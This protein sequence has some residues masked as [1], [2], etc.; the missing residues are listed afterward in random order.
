MSTHQTL[1][2][3]IAKHINDFPV[4]SHHS[5][6]RGDGEDIDMTREW[7]PGDKRIDPPTTSRTGTIMSR[8]FQESKQLNVW[9]LLD[10][11]HSMYFG[12]AVSKIEV[13][14]VIMTAIGISATGSRDTIG[15]IT[16]NS[17]IRHFTPLSLDSSTCQLIGKEI[18]NQHP[19]IQ[20]TSLTSALQRLA[21]ACQNNSLVCILSDFLTPPTHEDERL[22]NMI[23]SQP[24]VECVALVIRDDSQQK[25]KMPFMTSIRDSEDEAV[26][27][28]DARSSTLSHHEERHANAWEHNLK[29]VFARC[30]CPHLFLHI[31]TRYLRTLAR[32]FARKD[33]SL[34]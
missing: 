5:L 21:G 7:Q 30:R 28:T 19:P 26:V 29:Q 23:A 24:S 32:Y 11:S 34:A 25:I 22:M 33:A 3:L 15:V 27:S 18:L 1:Q 14:S 8:T 20:K 17:D 31:D 6:F 16:Y 12:L 2:L 9:V 4:G 13:A 10:I